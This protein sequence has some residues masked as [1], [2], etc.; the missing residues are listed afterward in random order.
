[1]ERDVDGAF[2]KLRVGAGEGPPTE[3]G[4]FFRAM[5]MFSNYTVLMECNS[6]ST[7]SH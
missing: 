7:Q 1:M 5:K 4:F 6:E 3:M 2:N